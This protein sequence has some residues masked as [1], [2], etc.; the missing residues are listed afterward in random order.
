MNETQ[1][2][3]RLEARIRDFERNMDRAEKRA[4]KAYGGMTRGSSQAARRVESDF[5]RMAGRVNGTLAGVGRQFVGIFAA[6]ASVRGAQQLIDTSVRITNA[7]KV[8]G[9]ESEAL[10]STY[11]S[12][13][14]SAQ[15]NSAPLESLIT[16]YGR[17]ALVQNELGVSSGQ[18]VQFTDNVA[19]AL[20]VAGVDAQ[21]ASGALLQL[22]Q[23]LGSGVVRAEEFNSILEGAPTILQA[24]AAGIKQAEG[25][26]AKLRNIML[27]GELSS[28]ALFDGIAAGS[29]LMEERVSGAESTISARL[30]RLS[31]VLV[32]AAKEFND[33][34]SAAE[35]LGGMI[36]GV[37]ESIE[38]INFQNIINEVDRVV[39]AITDGIGSLQ[40]FGREVGRVSGL[41]NVS[42]LLYG[43]QPNWIGSYSMP[44]VQDRVAAAFEGTPQNNGA[45]TPEAI[46]RSAAGAV[47]KGGRL[48]ASGGTN[49]IDLEDALYRPGAD[50]GSGRSGSRGSP[51]ERADE[52]ER[53]V[54]RITEARAATLAETEAVAGLNPVVEDYG[55]AL[56]KARATQDLLTAAQ[57][58]G[59]TVTPELSAEI[60]KLAASYAQATADAAKLSESQEEIRRKSDEMRDFQKDLSRGIVDGFLEGASAADVFANA[61]SKIGDRLLDMAFDSAFSGKGG[62]GLLS[63]I[64]GGLGGGG[65][66]QLA[67]AFGGGVGLYSDG[68]Y[69]GPGGKYQPAGIVH[70]GEYVVDADTVRKIGVGNL[71]R[72]KGYA[73]GGLVGAS[74]PAV[75]APVMPQVGGLSP[76]GGGMTVHVDA[77]TTID[78]KGADEAGLRRVERRLDRLQADLPARII[79]TVRD[80]PKKRQ[81]Q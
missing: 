44:A 27:D 58:A 42:R 70:R 79:T 57:Q 25:S 74:M 37:S 30:Q 3:I 17:V 21:S 13:F 31:N 10:E 65:G 14:A 81:M 53:L 36:D 68:G 39:S 55:F 51:K 61:L 23:A 19:L 45:L 63:G 11:Q 43:A 80:M 16:L 2:A 69:T 56:E 18:L 5:N 50:S 75:S 59:K 54:Q 6:G 71:E 40:A 35:G 78:A 1:L 15:R 38:Q 77:R 24:A 76:A 8:A 34:S 48:P 67:K 29:S 72:L 49:S 12:L 7:L 60:D 62:G 46:Q 64:L 66:S 47:P 4:A 41:E 28:R 52:Y 33:T 9:L 32:D 26:V 20:R 73:S 22:S